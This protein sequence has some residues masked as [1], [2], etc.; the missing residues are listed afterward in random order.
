MVLSPVMDINHVLTPHVLVFYVT[1]LPLGVK[2]IS[3]DQ[4]MQ[5]QGYFSNPGLRV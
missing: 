2:F 4:G 3:Q 1:S 5:T